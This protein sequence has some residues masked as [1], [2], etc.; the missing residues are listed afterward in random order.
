M[1]EILNA[2]NNKL[3]GGGIFCDIVIVLISLCVIMT[4]CYWSKKLME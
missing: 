1:N 4:A 3:V 2:L